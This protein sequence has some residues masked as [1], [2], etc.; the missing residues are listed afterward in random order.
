VT[1]GEA[2]ALRQDPRYWTLGIIY[3]CSEDSRVIVQRR[4]LPGW[5]VNFGHSL[6]VPTLFASVLV[7]IGPVLL[8]LLSGIRHL[9]SLI[10]TAC[11]SVVALI[12]VAHRVASGPR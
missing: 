1:R 7:A 4:L 3:R 9:P 5:T 10:V 6:A 12:A 2:E 8:L 11:L